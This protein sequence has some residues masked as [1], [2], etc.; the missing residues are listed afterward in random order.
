MIK[1][2]VYYN[3]S[4]RT[5]KVVCYGGAMHRRELRGYLPC[6][7]DHPRAAVMVF[8]L[9]KEFVNKYSFLHTPDPV[10]A[11]LVDYTLNMDTKRG[12]IEYVFELVE[13]D[14]VGL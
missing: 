10:E 8:D 4:K 7:L 13:Q 2:K 1:A 14:V 12:N 3:K 5:A 6:E 9:V 11:K